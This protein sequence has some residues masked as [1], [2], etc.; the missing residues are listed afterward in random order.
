MRSLPFLLAATA[1]SVVAIT[2]CTGGPGPLPDDQSGGTGTADRPTTTGESAGQGDDR[3]GSDDNGSGGKGSDD[4]G[5]DDNDD[6][7]GG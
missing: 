2:A 6:R 4:T 1:A 5:P 7:D 3:T